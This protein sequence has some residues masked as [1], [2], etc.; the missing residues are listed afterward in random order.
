[1]IRR[2]E[3]LLPFITLHLINDYFH[4]SG[5]TPTNRALHKV[6]AVKN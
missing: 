3:N 4:N 5:K 2:S 1:M 6:F